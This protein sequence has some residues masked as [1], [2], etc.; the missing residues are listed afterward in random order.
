M[1]HFGFC[2][3]GVNFG[4]NWM[5]RSSTVYNSDGTLESKS[6]LLDPIQS[7]REFLQKD[8]EVIR[9]MENCTKK[10]I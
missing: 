3:S 10:R 4:I 2:E 5:Q 8:F 7:F 1:A 9:S 6:K